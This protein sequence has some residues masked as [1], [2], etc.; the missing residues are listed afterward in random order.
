MNIHSITHAPISGRDELT[1]SKVLPPSTV[2]VIAC[3]FPPFFCKFHAIVRLSNWGNI[4]ASCSI[5]AGFALR[6]AADVGGLAAPGLSHHRATRTVIA[7][8]TRIWGMLRVC[9]AIVVAFLNLKASALRICGG[10]GG[11]GVRRMGFSD[12]KYLEFL[13]V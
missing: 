3:T 13:R 8:K 9:S 7:R 1:C 5:C 10:R 2:S 4:C 6:F 11:S 12:I